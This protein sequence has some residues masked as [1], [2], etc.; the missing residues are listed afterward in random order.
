MTLGVLGDPTSYM[1]TRYDIQ[2]TMKKA[3]ELIPKVADDFKKAFGR[4]AGGLLETYMTDDAEKVLVVKGSLA[5]TAK[6]VVDE[7][8]KEGSKVGLVKVITHRPFPEEA[9]E[10]ALKG[11][12][13]IGVVEK[14]ISLGAY[15][16]LY[17][18]IRAVFCGKKKVPNI[19]GFVI[20]L[21]GR[22]IDKESIRHIF[23]RLSEKGPANEFIGLKL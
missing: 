18:D 10:R 6:D 9:I 16:P 13:F 19:N 7:M 22:D 3:L 2:E 21:G 8:R 5:G 23:G 15:G 4:K 20:G 17:T 12:K 14:S 11:I 1:E